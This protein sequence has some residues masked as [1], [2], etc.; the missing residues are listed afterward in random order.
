MNCCVCF[1]LLSAIMVASPVWAQQ[2]AFDS[3]G[4]KINYF[5]QGSGEVVVLL[6]GFGGSSLETWQSLPLAKTQF[7]HELSKHYRVIAPDLRGH[8]NS[9]KPHDPTQYGVEMAKDVLRL[10][11]HLTIKKAH[12]VAYSMGSS[13]AGKL[14]VDNPDRLLSVV[15]GGGGPL[16]RQ[17]KGFTEAIDATAESLE[18][19]TGIGPLL[20]ALV[21]EGQPKPSPAQSDAISKMVLGDKDQRALAAVLRGQKQLE[22]TEK[23]L[24]AINVPV[25]FVY[26]SRD[27]LL[28]ELATASHRLITASRVQVVEGGDHMST[29]ASSEFLAA[30]IDFIGKQSD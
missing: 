30:V 27:T 12:I 3:N 1:A 2:K 13:I 21:P 16:F 25:L 10:L 26:G 28:K 5:D 7:L 22:V 9:D 24:E 17:P 23:D 15:F 11:D 20:V 8:G 29:V 4:V 19:G 6:H 14:L 18:R